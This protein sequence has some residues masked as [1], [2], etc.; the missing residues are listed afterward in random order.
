MSVTIN[1]VIVAGNLTRDPDL[2]ALEGG[3][4]VTRLSLALNRHWRGS[5]GERKEEVTYIE[6]E[7]WGR[8]AE[9]AGQYLNKGSACLVEGRLKMDQWQSQDGKTKPP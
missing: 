7:A 4:V 8:S 9:L 3:R 1:R 2:K 6:C 5:D